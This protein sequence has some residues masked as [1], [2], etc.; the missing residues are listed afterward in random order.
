MIKIITSS[1]ILQTGVATQTGLADFTQP[2]YLDR[3]T[4]QLPLSIAVFVLLAIGLTAALALYNF[5]LRNTAASNVVIGDWTIHSNQLV[6]GLQQLLLV[7][8]LLLFGFGICSTLAARQ[9][10]W[11]QTRVTKKTSPVANEFIQQS[12]PQVT[13][14]N[15]EPYIYTTQLDGKLVKVEDKKEVTRQSSVSGSNLLVSIAPARINA[16][17]GNNHLIDFSGDY[18]ITNAINTTDKFVFQ[19]SPPKGYAL[20]Q[21][22]GVEQD[23]K[24]LAR[25]NPGDYRFP[26]QIAPGS[27]SKLRVTYRVQGSPQWVYSAK[28]G[29]L[30][31]FQMAISTKVPRLNAINGVVPTKISRKG[32]RQVFSWAFNRNASV[33]KPFGVSVTPPVAEQTGKLPLLL[34]LA[35]AILLWWLLLLCFSMPMQLQNIAIAGCVFLAGMFGLTYSSRLADPIYVWS[36]ISI[37]LLCLVWGLGR[38]NWRISLVAVISTILGAIFPVYSFLLGS[39]GVLL[40]IAA[41]LSV[42]WLV[43]RNWYGWYPL[44]PSANSLVRVASASADDDTSAEQLLPGHRDQDRLEESATYNQLNPAALTAEEIAQRSR[45]EGLKK[46]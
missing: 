3:I 22:F 46:D 41:L 25:T 35:P 10:N 16:G 24:K 38:G 31:N 12:S 13:Y 39:R 42:I 8:L 29:S 23:G 43:G 2:Q 9:N 37:G 19:I 14:T 17:E 20:L 34:L 36:G 11:E 28:D 27:I 4:N 21:N 40:S 45:D 1:W 32:D 6:R 18:Q 7:A 26:I 5:S 15:L 44:A 33:Q 30:S